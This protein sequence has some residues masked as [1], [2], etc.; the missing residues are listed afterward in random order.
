ML[1]SPLRYNDY[2]HG[3]FSISDE[4]QTVLV[5]SDQFLRQVRLNITRHEGV[6]GQTRI[7]YTIVYNQVSCFY[8]I[9]INFSVLLTFVKHYYAFILLFEFC[10]NYIDFHSFVLQN[11]LTKVCYS[12]V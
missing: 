7:T 8:S 2:P 3:R 5:T 1:L 9:E 6:V 11:E 12:H 4:D 10:G